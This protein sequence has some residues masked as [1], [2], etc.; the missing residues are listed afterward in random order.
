MASEKHEKLKTKKHIKG[1]DI[2]RKLVHTTL[3]V[4]G[5]ISSC[6]RVTRWSDDDAML[7]ILNPTPSVHQTPY[8]CLLLVGYPL[9]WICKGNPW[10]SGPTIEYKDQK[11]KNRKRITKTKKM[12]NQK[13][14]QTKQ[15]CKP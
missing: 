13:K 8:Y 15:T 11:T 9:P 7:E 12:Q 5:I 14:K 2:K 6:P 10:A 4:L 1:N 3:A